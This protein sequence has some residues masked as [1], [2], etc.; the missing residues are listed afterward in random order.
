[1]GMSLPTLNTSI[2][3]IRLHEYNVALGDR[4]WSFL[5][6][7]V[8]VTREQEREFFSREE[9]LLPYGAILWPAS[10][11]LAH[12]VLEQGAML[13]GKRV[14]E[15][16]AGTGVPGI[17][18]ASFGAKVLQTD[19]HQVAVHLCKLNAER[20]RVANS[21][22]R[23]VD[24]ETFHSDEPFDLILGGDVLYMTTM[25]A[26]LQE[27][28]ER[29]LAPGGAALFSDPFRKQSLPMLEKMESDGWQVSLSKWSIEVEK[30]TRSIAVYRA[31]RR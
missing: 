5:H 11:A 31:A 4:K 14:L 18:A 28:C 20:N 15:L 30:G 17:V 22:V 3:E 12:E 16:G 27:I 10:I 6:T 25:H 21:E 19:R 13:A 24:W 23:E 26:R 7:G 8:I 1:M 29:Y 9:E 2:G